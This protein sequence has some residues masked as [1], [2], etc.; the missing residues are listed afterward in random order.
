M[1]KLKIYHNPRCSKSRETLQLINNAQADV[2][3]IDYQKAS[4]TKKE[5][6]DVLM[7]L[8]MI[9][10]QIVRK[11]ETL[12]KS[13]YKDKKF[14]NEEWIQILIENP[15]L[16]ERPIVIK[17]NKAVLGRPPENVNELL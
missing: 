13:N 15:I 6:E 12:Y 2:E 10:E 1:S 3:I 11:G 9:P 14:S 17:G 4:I 16:I 5:L 8:N 7:K